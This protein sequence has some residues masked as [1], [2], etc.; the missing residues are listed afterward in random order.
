MTIPSHADSV[1][2]IELVAH[3]DAGDRRLWAGDQD[4]RPLSELGHGQAAR[5]TEVLAASPVDAFYSSPALRCRQTLAPLAARFELPIIVVP[6][7]RETDGFLPP[8]GWTRPPWPDECPDPHGGA[9]AAGRAWSALRQIRAMSP[10]GRV[11]VCTHGDIA[12]ALIAFLVGAESLSP[13]PALVWRGGWYTISIAASKLDV[14]HHDAP[15][16]FPR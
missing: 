11:A 14:Q 15:S 2:T 4:V 12:P 5:M 8:A 9:Y 13:P 1:L 10:V 6:D 16:D 7:L 3:M